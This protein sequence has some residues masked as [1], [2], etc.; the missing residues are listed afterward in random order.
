[1]LAELDQR[2]RQSGIELQFAEMKGPVKDKLKRFELF[3]R[4]GAFHPT[5]NAAVDSYVE[6]QAMNENK[7]V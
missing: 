7:K 5:V 6:E 3:D 2:L 4:F 1:M